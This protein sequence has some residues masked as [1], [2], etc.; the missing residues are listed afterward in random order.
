MPGPTR[1]TVPPARAGGRDAIA[2][3]VAHLP[4]GLALD[5]AMAARG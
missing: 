1:T 3:V 5:D 2:V 4:F